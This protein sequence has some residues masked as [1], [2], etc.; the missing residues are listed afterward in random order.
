MRANE[1]ITEVFDKGYFRIRWDEKS[2]AEWDGGFKASDGSIIHIFF[3]LMDNDDT[4]HVE[5][6]RNSTQDRI[7]TPPKLAIKILSTINAALKQFIRKEQPVSI[8]VGVTNNDVKKLEV[9]HKMLGALNYHWEKMSRQEIRKYNL[10]PNNLWYRYWMGSD[11]DDELYGELDEDWKKTLGTVGAAG[12]LALGAN[13]F[14]KPKAEFQPVTR[15]ELPAAQP[16][17]PAHKDP[18]KVL[19]YTMWGEARDQGVSGMLAIGNVIKNRAKD[20]AHARRFGQG[21]VGVATKPKQFSCW[22]PN[23]PNFT[24]AKEMEHID[25]I[26]KSKRAPKGQDFNAWLK[27][28]ENTGKY[29][30]YKTWL[31]SYEL[32]KKIVSGHAPDPTHG[33]VYYHAKGIHPYWAK[34]TKKLA[35]VGDHVFYAMPKDVKESVVDEYKVDNVDGLGSVPLNSNV[36]YRGLRV[37]MR[38]STFLKLALPLSEPPSKKY[39]MQHLKNGGGLGAPFL[40]IDIPEKWFEG[41]FADYAK[42][43]GHEGRNRMMA[44]QELEGDEPVEVHLFPVGEVRARHLTPEVVDHLRSGMWNQAKDHIVTNGSRGIFL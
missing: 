28:F 26:I 2:G 21:I 25:K 13:S 10:K 23:D 29:L 6:S 44:V 42:V 9:Y 7:A 4:W 16:Q 39:I 32:A 19:A 15:I 20:E 11:E 22:N 3:M 14:I 41:N 34:G 31:K 30:D 36:D 17:Q 43:K 18:V 37:M 27:E 1:F 35:T 38:P 5:W 33:A 24:Y 8:I 40:T 12:A